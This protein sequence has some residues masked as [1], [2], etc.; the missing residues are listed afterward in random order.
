MPIRTKRVGERQQRQTYP[1]V[2]R[3]YE[4]EEGLALIGRLAELRGL[5]Q[6]ALLRQ[7]IR[8]EARRVKLLPRDWGAAAEAM[9]AYYEN[10]P[11]VAE[12]LHWDEGVLDYAPDDPQSRQQAG[13]SDTASQR[14]SA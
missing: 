3:A 8:E 11:E 1:H 10:D 14:D 13:D 6:A 5:S 9:R 12:W 2:V 7:L 4:S